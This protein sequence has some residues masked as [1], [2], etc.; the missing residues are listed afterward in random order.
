M[1]IEKRGGFILVLLA[2]GAISRRAKIHAGPPRHAG[3]THFR[4]RFASTTAQRAGS[5]RSPPAAANRDSVEELLAYRVP[6]DGSPLL[7]GELP[8]LGADLQLMLLAPDYKLLIREVIDPLRNG[9]PSARYHRSPVY[10]CLALSLLPI[11]PLRPEGAR[12]ARTVYFFS[13]PSPTPG[14]SERALSPP[15]AAQPP[16]RQC[17]P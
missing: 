4:C 17:H 7:F 13:W 8:H 9:H 14:L 6:K 15:L 11:G 2:G 1:A 10:H 12:G 16:E 5:R 3:S